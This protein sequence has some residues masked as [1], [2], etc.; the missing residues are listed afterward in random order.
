MRKKFIVDCRG[1]KLTLGEKTRVMGIL[2]V[3]PDSFSDGGLFFDFKKAVRRGIEIEKEGADIL[4]IGGES[5]RPG[6]LGVS[7]PDQ[8]KRVVP[9]IKA[10]KYKIKIPISIDT[11]DSDVARE[12]VLAGARIINDITGL[13]KDKNIAAVAAEYKTGLCIMHIKGA[14]RNMQDAPRYKDLMKEAC[15]WLNEGVR[16]ARHAGVSDNRIII[17]PGIGFGKSL[18]HN[19]KILKN[20]SELKK[21]NRPVL[22][23]P[24]RK[25]F[26]GKLLDLPVNERI[27]GTVAAVS[28]SIANGA[29]IVRAHDVKQIKQAARIVDAILGA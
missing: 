11:S 17:D 24:S 12:A 14:P 6:S 19:L 13:R 27:M 29:H 8:I 25:P 10:L 5:T 18:K 26:I 2:N 22:I 16:I 3:T 20:L 23:G 28:I 9:V 4:D 15:E 1:Y 21:I 7:A